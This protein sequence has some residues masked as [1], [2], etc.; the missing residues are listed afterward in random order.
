MRQLRR[1]VLSVEHLPD[2]HRLRN[3]RPGLRIEQHRHHHPVDLPN[4]RQ[5]GRP[6]LQQQQLHRGRS[7]MHLLEHDR[8]ILLSGLR[9]PQPAL[10][11]ELD[12]QHDRLQRGKYCL[13]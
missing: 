9:W 2:R 12:K 13:R 7:A 4:M 3:L 6:L 1:A 5:N 8:Q 10:L 11:L